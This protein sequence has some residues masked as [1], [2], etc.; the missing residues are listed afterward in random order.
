MRLT[1]C[2]NIMSIIKAEMMINN[3]FILDFLEILLSHAT[4]IVSAE[5]SLID[6]LLLFKTINM[7]S[8][9]FNKGIDVIK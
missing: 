1:A 2:S 7:I 6:L 8:A 5:K 4:T 9:I 3:I